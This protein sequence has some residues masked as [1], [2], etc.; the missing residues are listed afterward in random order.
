VYSAPYGKIALPA[1]LTQQGKAQASSSLTL[2]KP[3]QNAHLKDQNRAIYDPMD[4]L[5]IIVS[6]KTRVTNFEE[7]VAK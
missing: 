6:Q 3:N 7:I 4:F 5:A 1:Q 2:R